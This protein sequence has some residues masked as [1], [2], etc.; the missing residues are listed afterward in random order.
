[1]L[2][3]AIGLLHLVFALA[4]P[5]LSSDVFSYVAYGRLGALHG[6]DPYAHPPLAAHG[7]PVLIY[8]AHAWRDAL[9]AYGP[10]FTLLT[11]VLAPL[12][13]AAAV[14]SL[15]NTTSGNGIPAA[16]DVLFN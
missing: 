7:D 11:Y 4:P 10:L 9:S 13:I 15:F 14:W 2:F 8:V 6:L 1:M 3:G 16:F 12:G 5:L